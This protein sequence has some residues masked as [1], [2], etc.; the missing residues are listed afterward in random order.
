MTEMLQG[1]GARMAADWAKKAGPD[2]EQLIKTISS[3]K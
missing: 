1:I 3:G 2:G